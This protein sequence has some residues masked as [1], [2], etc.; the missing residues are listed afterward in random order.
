[1][2]TKVKIVSLCREPM[3]IMSNRSNKEI[4]KYHF[5]GETL[6]VQYPRKICFY[7][8]G[9]ERYL[10]MNLRVGEV[11]NVQFDIE[12]RE[13][14][15]RWFTEC[16]CFNAE[17]ISNAGVKTNEPSVQVQ[18]PTMT[19]TQAQASNQVQEPSQEKVKEQEQEQDLPF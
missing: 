10:R 17:P 1:M 6:D 2:E 8:F 11:Y 19:T 14:N 4:V 16:V 5:V 7:V 15:E 12:S 3:R 9:D 13:W 18:T